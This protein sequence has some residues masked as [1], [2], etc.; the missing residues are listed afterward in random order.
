MEVMVK[1][2]WPK[3]KREAKYSVTANGQTRPFCFKHALEFTFIT[4]P[5]VEALPDE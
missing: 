3:C 2:S 1:C 4:S 5:E